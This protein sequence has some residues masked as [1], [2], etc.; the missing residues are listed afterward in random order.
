M[1][2]KLTDR[3]PFIGRPTVKID[4]VPFFTQALSGKYRDIEV[5]GDAGRVGRFSSASVDADLHGVH[6]P[7]RSALNGVNE[8]PVDEADVRVHVTLAV[9]AAATGVK[10][11]TMTAAGS[12]DHFARTDCPAGGWA[13]RR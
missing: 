1:A 2:D 11:L 9:L 10:G 4:G 6:L 8:V 7:I 5:S 12:G 13:L 3:R